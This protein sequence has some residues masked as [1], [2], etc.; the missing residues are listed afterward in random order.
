MGED[1]DWK[2]SKTKL[3]SEIPKRSRDERYNRA[4][5]GRISPP[6]D[7]EHLGNLIGNLLQHGLVT[8][9][10]GAFL[11]VNIDQVPFSLVYFRY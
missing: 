6:S 8:P 5:Q 10:G 7:A 2:L 3:A 11:F 4:L 9:L 1:E